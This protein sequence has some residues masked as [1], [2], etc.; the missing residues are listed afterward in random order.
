MIP[1]KLDEYGWMLCPCGMHN[2]Q[3]TGKM[4]T[5]VDGVL[6]GMRGPI[7]ALRFTCEGGHD[8]WLCFGFHEGITQVFCEPIID[9]NAAPKV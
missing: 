5:I 7:T 8:F 9:L 3:A 6:Y 1:F 2:V 4:A